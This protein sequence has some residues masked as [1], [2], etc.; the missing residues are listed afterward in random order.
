MTVFAGAYSLDPNGNVPQF[1]KEALKSNLRS[2]VDS[3]GTWFD[4]DQK[5]VF[6]I[7]WDSGAF[8]ESAW[9]VSA[10]ESLSTLVG[11]PLFTESGERLK[12]D[13]Q[14]LRL[15]KPDGGL[16]N[17][18]LA[19]TR[20][21]FSI[22]RYETKSQTLTLS[23]DMVGL[24]SVYYTVQ[25]GNFIFAS[26][27]RVLEAMACVRKK[28]SIEGMVE[29]AVFSFPLADRTPYAGI[30]VLRECEVL[31]VDSMGIE[32]NSYY[33]W[34]SVG[35]IPDTP[36]KAAEVLFAEFK[37]AIRI[38]GGSDQKAYAFLSGGM[39]SRAIVGSLLKS[40]CKVEAL[41]FSPD[42]SQDQAYARAFANVVGSQC[43]LHC[44]DLLTDKQLHCNYSP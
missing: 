17:G 28:L 42:A 8:N 13:I 37:E 2:V 23:T 33:D 29:F 20:G 41:N 16:S 35:S 11:D 7:K 24:R 18:E 27:I 34:T 38:R 9:Q 6:L 12:R 25:D 32:L 43:H 21:A 30:S 1:L 39:D 44:F 15:V 31:T 40:G 22:A 5:R 4:Y 36:A 3:R 26:A 19:Q 14:L 10:D